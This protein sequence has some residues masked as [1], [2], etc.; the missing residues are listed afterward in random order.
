MTAQQSVKTIN[1]KIVE[2]SLPSFVVQS[3]NILFYYY[4]P[5]YSHD[6]T[7]I[8]VLSM[9]EPVTTKLIRKCS[10]LGDRG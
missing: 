10:K 1:I 4:F 6:I 2:V 5:T 3:K 9:K 8:F 7:L